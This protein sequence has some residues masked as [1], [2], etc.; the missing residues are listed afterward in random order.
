MKQYQFPHP[1]VIVPVSDGDMFIFS[2]AMNIPDVTLQFLLED[3]HMTYSVKVKAG[4]TFV[5]GAWSERKPKVPQDLNVVIRVD[6]ISPNSFTTYLNGDFIATTEA[7]RGHRI[8]KVGIFHAG[9]IDLAIFDFGDREMAEVFGE[10]MRNPAPNDL[11]TREMDR[12][13]LAIDGSDMIAS[14]PDREKSSK[15]R[16]KEVADREQEVACREREVADREKGVAGRERDVADR[17]KG[18]AGREK[19]VAG[20]EK[21]VLEKEKALEAREKAVE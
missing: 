15:A 17:E 10:A 5:E 6:K 20:R 3:N 8:D 18:V 12:K 13:R 16:E 21:L 19:E 14:A 4:A 9:G 7:Y 11:E 2:F 1:G